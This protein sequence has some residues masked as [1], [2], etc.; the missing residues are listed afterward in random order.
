MCAAAPGGHTPLLLSTFLAFPGLDNYVCDRLYP[1]IEV[2]NPMWPI[3]CLLGVLCMHFITLYDYIGC[4]Y[5]SHLWWYKCQCSYT[6]LST[7]FTDIR[8]NWPL[9]LGMPRCIWGHGAFA[10]GYLLSMVY[11][12]HRS[13][14]SD[15][16]TQISGLGISDV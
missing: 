7:P 10:Q 8:V 3:L 15:V 6:D 13:L 11:T 16:C 5:S 9:S 4:C 12:Y 2:S 1:C 14:I